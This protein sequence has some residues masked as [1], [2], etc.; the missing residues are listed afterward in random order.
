MR[1]RAS[2]TFL[3]W[4]FSMAWPMCS[5][6]ML[7]QLVLLNKCLW[8][9]TIV[10]LLSLISPVMPSTM[11]LTCA[12]TSINDAARR[13]FKS[14]MMHFL[15]TIAD[16]LLLVIY[17][18]QRRTFV[19]THTK[20]DSWPLKH[21]HTMLLGLITSKTASNSSTKQ[22][23]QKPWWIVPGDLITVIGSH[24]QIARMIFLQMPFTVYGNH[25]DITWS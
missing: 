22:Q 5:I 13:C 7:W 24:L 4:R 8:V 12:V 21:L 18:G 19:A 20:A 23:F 9:C 16:P 11:F 17:G 10:L 14:F 3:R 6:V 15:K 25:V 1:G 2:D